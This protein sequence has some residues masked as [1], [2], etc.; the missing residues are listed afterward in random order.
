MQVMHVSWPYA[1][2]TAIILTAL[3]CLMAFLSLLI[4]IASFLM[5]VPRDEEVSVTR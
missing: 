4:F 2:L 5:G 1:E 3:G